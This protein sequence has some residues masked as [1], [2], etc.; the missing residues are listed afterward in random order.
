MKLIHRFILIL[1][2]LLAM[3]F[4][5]TAQSDTIVS[6]ITC[7]PGSDIYELE[8]HTAL[9]IRSPRFDVAVSYGVFDFNSPNFVYRFVKGETDYMCAA[10]PWQIFEAEY[11]HDGRRVVEQVLDLDAEQTRKLVELVDNNLLPQNRVY[12]YNYVK[13]N[14]ATRPLSIIEQAVGDSLQLTPVDFDTRSYTASFRDVMRHYHRNYP[15][16]QFGIDLALGSGIDYPISNREYTFAPVLL[17]QQLADATV[18]GH[19]IVKS[20]EVIVGDDSWNSVDD[21]TPFFLTPMF[22]GWVVFALLLWAT[23]CDNR[24]GRVSKW[25]DAAYFGV[26]GLAGLLITF[27]VFISVHEATSP[28]YLIIW[29]NP[30]CLIPTIFIWLKK[31]KIVVL[32]YQIINFAAVLILC[33]GWL[34]LPQSANAAFLPFVLGDLLRSASYIKLNFPK[35]ANHGK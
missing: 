4:M 27:L 7:A 28:N 32:S 1:A 9:R 20:T 3:P 33:L 21:A 29:L 30:F 17:E 10:I 12:R 5:A 34:W 16:Y 19:R 22:V 11:R 26:L 2:W 31:C 8:G 15:W 23:V 18:G 6:L 35:V 25:I 24:R 14:C 13:D